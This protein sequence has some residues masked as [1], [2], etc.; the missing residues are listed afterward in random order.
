MNYAQL[1][2]AVYFYTENTELT[3]DQISTFVKQAEQRVYNSVNLLP[4]RKNVTGTMTANNKYVTLP[5]DF[6]APFS[7]TAVAPSGSQTFLLDKDV[8]Y[9]RE[10][11]PDPS[12]TGTT[13]HYALFDANTVLLGPTPNAAYGTEL[14]YFYYPESIVTAGT[15][16]LGNNFDSVLLY[17]TLLE[18]YTFMKGEP[19]LMAQYQKQYDTAMALLKQLGDGKTRQDT[20]RSGQ[21]R[22][23]I[24]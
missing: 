7:L 19:D 9:M 23:P 11:F 3:T 17:G 21:V 1:T 6:L 22:Y 12:V 20:Y 8:S 5:T 15:S 24:K 4:L 10:A 2:S 18:A 16:W 13:T 14:H